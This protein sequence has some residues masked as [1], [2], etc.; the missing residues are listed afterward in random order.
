MYNA[1][2]YVTQSVASGLSWVTD[3]FVTQTMREFYWEYLWKG[4]TPEDVCKEFGG[5]RSR[6]WM[7]NAENFAE[8]L[9][10]MER[11]FRSWQ[12]GIMAAMELALIGYVV[13]ILLCCNCIH[14]PPRE[15][16][17]CT[18]TASATITVE[19]L[20]EMLATPSHQ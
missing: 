5:G 17:Q 4:E 13:V 16:H 20:R 8:C 6:H 1:I 3:K 7:N 15:C 18:H 10:E 14:R 12:R 2:R 11:H 19:Q 9:L